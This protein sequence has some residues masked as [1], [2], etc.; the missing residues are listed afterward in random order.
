MVM[1][2]VN[3]K[4]RQS[5]PE[6]LSSQGTVDF[7]LK[8]GTLTVKYH[9]KGGVPNGRYTVFTM[10]CVA[11]Y[12]NLNGGDSVVCTGGNDALVEWGAN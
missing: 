3:W 7:Q 9:I 1:P 4:P 2:D 10:T 8:G 5:Q 11:G 6:G 12:G